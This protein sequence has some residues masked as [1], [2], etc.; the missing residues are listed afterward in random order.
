MLFQ[1]LK[2]SCYRHVRYQTNNKNTQV[3]HLQYILLFAMMYSIF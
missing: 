1:V 3:P 2:D